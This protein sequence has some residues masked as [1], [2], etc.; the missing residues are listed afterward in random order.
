VAR[1]LQVLQDLAIEGLQVPRQ[2]YF[3]FR[4]PAPLAGMA[5]PGTG[6]PWRELYGL[7]F[8]NVVCLCGSRVEYGPAPLRILQA[9]EME[10]LQHGNDP[11]YPAMNERLARDAVDIINAHLVKGEGVA[12]HCVGG[13]GRTG[14]VIG[15]VLRSRGYTADEAISYLDEI[16]KLRGRRWP[17]AP[18]QADMVR[19]Y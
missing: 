16:N 9:V 7:G 6:M 11:R 3:V 14:T 10:D 4:E 5:Y 19:R 12:V 13:T 8:R 18:W 17:E 15:C 1:Q 2:F